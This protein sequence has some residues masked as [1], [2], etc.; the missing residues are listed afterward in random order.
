MSEDL[1]SSV[2]SSQMAENLTDTAPVGPHFI[3]DEN[4]FPFGYPASICQGTPEPK[5]LCCGCHNVLKK[6][7]QTL[8]GHRYCA[9]CLSWILRISKNP[10]CSRCQEENPQT[11]GDE[12]FL[13]EEKAFIDAAINKEISELSVHCVISG[14][15]WTGLMKNFETHVCGGVSLKDHKQTMPKIDTEEKDSLVPAEVQDR[16]PFADIGCS[17]KGGQERVKEHEASSLSD[18]LR[19]L[20]ELAIRGKAQWGPSRGPGASG[21]R[22]AALPEPKA[23]ERNLSDLQLQGAVEVNGDLEADYFHA[24]SSDS[25]EELV[26]QRFM[27]EKLLAELEE[28]LRVF[29][30]IVTVL[31]KEVEA[32]HLAIAASVYQSG[33]TQDLILSLEQ[34]VVD[35]Q[36]TLTQKDLALTKLEQTLHL[37]EEA[38]YDGVY[39]WKITNF[40]RRC[41]ESAC[42]RTVSLFSPAFYTARYGYKL[43]LR[44]YLN[45]DGMGK[46]THLSLFIVVM[47][48]KYDALLEWPF[49]NK[50]TF[51]LLDQNNREHVTDS[52]HPDLTSGSFQ[53]PQGESNI[54]SGR[55]MFFPLNKLQ[56]S[57]H[58]YVK[59]DT[60]FLKCVIETNS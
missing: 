20:L 3:P 40:T 50:V 6:A 59:D 47:K 23:T 48:G 35:L 15:G 45:G 56:S 19:L 21:H 30:N 38:S 58:A 46:G 14:C 53:K 25:E 55:P 33:L 18:H 12:S 22:H 1:S 44:I 49:R 36:Q 57:K 43:C 29:E 54:A 28:K 5:Y 42:G 13:S 34:R 52:F 26:L 24:A 27:K 41:H 7:Q 11:V 9:A 17:F 2:K 39:L 51:M 10:I 4:E 37:L 32:S 60:L 16:C 8:C 31:N